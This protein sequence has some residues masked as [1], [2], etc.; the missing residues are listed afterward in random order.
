MD[1]NIKIIMIIAAGI[2]LFAVFFFMSAR[3]QKQQTRRRII[4]MWGKI[5]EREYEYEEFECISHYF[6]KQI[7]KES[8]QGVSIDDITWN[9]LD[10]DTIFCMMNN[11][12]SSIGQ[13]YLY[14]MLRTPMTEP[15]VLLERERLMKFFEEHGKE[16]VELQTLF[17]RIG[18]SKKLSIMD[19]ISNL[20]GVPVES[21]LR[22]YLL[23]GS[24]VVSLLL[25][26]VNVGMG[27]VILVL[28][29]FTSFTLYFKRKREIEP[30]IVTF[31]YIL[32]LLQ[33]ADGFV[34]I[35]I[36]EIA[37]YT[38]Q[39]KK[40]K[41]QFK[42]FKAG[43]VFLTSSGSMG[44]EFA[45]VLL[46]YIRILF[47]LDLIKFNV[48]RLELQKHYQEVEEILEQLGILESTIAVASFRESIPFYSCPHLTSQKQAF[49]RV[50][51]EYHPLIANPV[52][53]SIS[54]ERGALITGS[55]ASGKSTFLKTVA[56]N[57]IFAQTIYTCLATHYESCFFQLYSSMALTDHLEKQ[58]SYYIV[59]IKSLKRILEHANDQLPILCFIDEVL[60]GTNTVERIAASAQILK[61][62]AKEHILCFA[63]THDVELTHLLEA[64][65]SNYHFQEE[66]KE[67]DI[68][69]NYQLQKGRAISRNAIKLLSIIGYEEDII[70]KAEQ[71]AGHFIETGQWRL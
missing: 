44:G 15:S 50:K 17:H 9:D 10:M 68:L 64:D 16:R 65:Y 3:E 34:G 43:S 1:G 36:P 56:I 66:I 19:Y 48:M 37:A 49:L 52:A 26:N 33:G 29:I 13:E 54:E 28:S 63:A 12:Y 6:R 35:K 11:T 58:E 41:S 31:E 22:H 42:K 14:Y 23:L 45:D 51:D 25:M 57:A 46:D 21:N 30:Y 55:N 4:S 24:Y 62:L 32:K 67:N 2:L 5:P 7:Q 27:V 60:R 39:I 71:T 61:S 59:E 38:N 69:F 70:E 8:F 53:N 47:H 20:D 18:R 40:A